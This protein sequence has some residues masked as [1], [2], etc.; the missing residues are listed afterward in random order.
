MISAG[1]LIACEPDIEEGSFLCDTWVSDH[2][3]E[4]MICVF[5]RCYRGAWECSVYDSFGADIVVDNNSVIVQESAPCL[6]DEVC[7][8]YYAGIGEVSISDGSFPAEGPTK[9][10]KTAVLLP[11]CIGTLRQPACEGLAYMD[12]CDLS[13]HDMG[14]GGRCL[15]AAG[16]I[17]IQGTGPV[18]WQGN[19]VYSSGAPVGI[20]LSQTY[21]AVYAQPYLTC[22]YVSEA[23]NEVLEYLGEGICGDEILGP[24]EVCDGTS[25]HNLTCEAL[26][27][28]G[29]SLT[30]DASCMAIDLSGCTE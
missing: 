22:Q 17:T 28:S 20:F 25:F 6:P 29:G 7:G 21:G 2:C 15:P 10:A 16:T 13:G 30:C 14:G 5:G 11:H 24:H 23:A 18:S 12:S 9:S 27:F 19:T 3:P 4:G 26:G 8:L 1:L